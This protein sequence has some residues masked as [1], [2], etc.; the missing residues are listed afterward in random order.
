MSSLTPEYL[1][2]L[3]ETLR[4]QGVAL[5]PGLTA[6]Q[7]EAAQTAHGFRFPP[8]LRALLAFVLPVGERFPDWRE[9]HAAAIAERLAW[10]I[11]GVLGD[12]ED[13]GLW[14]PEWGARPPALPEALERARLA[15]QAAPRLIPVF[16]HRYLPASPCDAGNPVFSVYQADVIYYGYDLPSYLHTEFGVPNPFPMPDEPRQI[17]F[18]SVLADGA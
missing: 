14:W 13:N 8:D 3:A 1:E 11:D 12:V 9:P 2:A 7:I 16:G 4:A 15:M 6:A 5:A 17:A 18:W 10:P